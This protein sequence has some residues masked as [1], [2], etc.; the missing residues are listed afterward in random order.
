MK[1]Y[2][3][4]EL[5]DQFNKKIITRC[6]LE[7]SIFKYYFKNQGK[8]CLSHWNPDEYED[9]ISWFY[10]RLRKA[11][12]KYHDKGFS[13]ETFMNKYLF[14]ASKEYTTR[15][16]NG[17]IT[18]YSTWSARVP[19]LYVYEEPP[20]YFYGKNEKMISKI[21]RDK[22]G[23]KD[24]RRI[25]ALIIKCYNYV[26]DDFIEKVAPMLEIKK[27]EL[28]EMM[29]KIRKLRQKNDDTIYLIKEKLYYHFYRSIVIEKKLLLTKD[30]TVLYNKLKSQLTNTRIK[31]E[32]MRA[33][34]NLIKKDATN[35][36][37]AEVI[38]VCKGSID[39]GLYK[40][41]KKFDLN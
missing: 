31:L 13:F 9:F 15:T 32:K 2:I 1:K 4:N 7:S 11:I 23:R 19:D 24:T 26:S 33:K 25:L 21:I 30:N 37:V 39:S 18:E 28:N 22:N 16:T 20:E 17:S 34:L 3:L 38:G 10:P 35:S 12:D 40:L 14:V 41:K 6:K 8:T 36:Q 29:T 27:E 5:Y